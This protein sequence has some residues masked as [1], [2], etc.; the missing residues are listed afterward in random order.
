MI[1]IPDGSMNKFS[2]LLQKNEVNFVFFYAPW[3]GQS[4]NA[5]QEFRRAAN[6]LH[7]EVWVDKISIELQLVSV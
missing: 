5:A 7:K 1:E 6:I 2:D 3:C 4:W